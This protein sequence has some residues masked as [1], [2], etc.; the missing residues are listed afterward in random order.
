MGHFCFSVNVTPQRPCTA[1]SIHELS[2]RLVRMSCSSSHR[3]QRVGWETMG[4]Y[5]RGPVL[6]RNVSVKLTNGSQ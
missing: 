6:S 5:L 2:A 4:G 1:W 3:Q